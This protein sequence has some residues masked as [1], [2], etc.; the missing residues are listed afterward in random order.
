MIFIETHIGDPKVTI[1]T[2][3]DHNEAG[4]A[5]VTERKRFKGSYL[6]QMELFHFPFD[7]QVTKRG[8][9]LS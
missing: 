8:R 4:E 2:T 5:Y 7:V 6:E 9:A 1:N 3:V